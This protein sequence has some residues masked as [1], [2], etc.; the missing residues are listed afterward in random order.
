MRQFEATSVH[1]VCTPR[2]C[3]RGK[4]LDPDF[5]EWLQEGAWDLVRV[6]GA[7]GVQ[8]PKSLCNVGGLC[9]LWEVIFY[10]QK[11]VV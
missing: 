9:E 1:D 7:G 11:V 5:E 3:E 6:R 4:I 10:D 8:A 2:L